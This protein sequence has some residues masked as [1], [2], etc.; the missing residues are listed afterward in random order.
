MRRWRLV[1]G[2]TTDSLTETPSENAPTVTHQANQWDSAKMWSSRHGGFE[3]A[4]VLW[5]QEATLEYPLRWHQKGGAT[6]Q[7]DDAGRNGV[8]GK[9]KEEKWRP[10]KGP[11]AM[12]QTR[13]VRNLESWTVG[14]T[15]RASLFRGPNFLRL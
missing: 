1:D 5:A 11:N 14:D 6:N 15:V 2:E 8:L 13:P 3:E 4:L 7:R 9:R 10:G 12:G